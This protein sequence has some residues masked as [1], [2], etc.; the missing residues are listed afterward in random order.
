M[1]IRSIISNSI[2]MNIYVITHK[3]FIRVKSRYNIP[4]GLL[5]EC[6]VQCYKQLCH[7]L[8]IKT[9]NSRNLFMGWLNVNIGQENKLKIYV[10]LWTIDREICWILLDN[11]QKSKSVLIKTFWNLVI[12]SKQRNNGKVVFLS[13]ENV[14]YIY[15]RRIWIIDS[16]LDE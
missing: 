6:D 2:D 13:M 8:Q 1:T 15:V 4:G 16:L 3:K 5:T 12:F 11:V 10:R 14:I 7:Q 9:A